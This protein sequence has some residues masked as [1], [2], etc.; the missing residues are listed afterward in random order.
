M[1]IKMTRTDYTELCDIIYT[2]LDGLLCNDLL[3]IA[4]DI[5]NSDLDNCIDVVDEEDETGE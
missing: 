4:A 3:D 5:I 1:T 2:S